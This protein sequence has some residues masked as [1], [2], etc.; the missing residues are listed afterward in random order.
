MIFIKKIFL[1]FCFLFII[2]CASY[3]SL[4][5]TERIVYFNNGQSSFV[6]KYDDRLNQWF[7]A[8]CG[9]GLIIIFEECK[10]NFKFTDLSISH[11]EHLLSG[12]GDNN[13]SKSVVNTSTEENNSS[14]N[15]D[16]ELSDDDDWSEDD[17][18][19]EDDEEDMDG[20]EEP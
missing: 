7:R 6:E 4:S 17:E 13:I 11:M 2:G 14:E 1:L 15:D 3:K 18:D 9:D 20:Y 10:N 5:L 19:D 12:D 8:E 16:E